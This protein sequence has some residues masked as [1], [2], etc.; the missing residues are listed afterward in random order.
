MDLFPDGVALATGLIGVPSMIA[1][2]LHERQAAARAD[3]MHERELA[4]DV[5]V[6]PYQSPYP[7]GVHT[8]N[9]HGVL[10]ERT[11]APPADPVVADLPVPALPGVTTLDSLLAEGWRP[12]PDR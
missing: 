3:R 4:R 1:Y 10:P 6:A 2:K 7:A 5:A 12:A 11:P 9:L 8:L